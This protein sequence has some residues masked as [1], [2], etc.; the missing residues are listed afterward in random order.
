[1]SSKIL[2]ITLLL[3]SVS[4]CFQPSEGNRRF[5]NPR[6]SHPCCTKVSTAD[7]SKIVVGNKYQKQSAKNS[8]VEAI[9]LNTQ[10][11]QVCV[12]PKAHWVKNFIS[13]ME[14]Q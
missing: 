6:L 14:Q 5:P 9:I 10:E 4:L 7:V 1:M 12:D 8:C 2:V 11:G 3:L 13:S